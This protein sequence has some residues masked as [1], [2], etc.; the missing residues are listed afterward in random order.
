[1]ED[2][3]ASQDA[4]TLVPMSLSLVAK[5]EK[6]LQMEATK[7]EK[8]LA[9]RNEM[10]GGLRE[11]HEYLLT[12][13]GQLQER[14]HLRRVKLASL[15]SLL[16]ADQEHD[17]ADK[18]GLG[19]AIGVNELEATAEKCRVLKDILLGLV[20]KRAGLEQHCMGL[21]E[22]TARET[23]AL[24][25]KE[26]RLDEARNSYLLMH[27]D[28]RSTQ[29]NLEIDH[30]DLTE[31]DKH[32]NAV[33]QN[34]QRHAATVE[35]ADAALRAEKAAVEDLQTTW[36][37]YESMAHEEHRQLAI[38]NEDARSEQRELQ[39]L[40]E[41]NGAT[42][43]ADEKV[44][45]AAKDLQLRLQHLHEEVTSTTFFK[46]EIALRIK[47]EKDMLAITQSS[48]KAK[49]E[50]LTWL[51][52]Q[53]VHVENEQKEAAKAHAAD[54]AAYQ[55][56][57]EEHNT[58][59]AT[60]ETQIK[61]AGK[62]VKTTER[63][64]TA[65]NKK[66]AAVNKKVAHK[67][68]VL[69]EWKA[70]T[71]A[72]QDQVSKSAATQE[73]VDAEVLGMQE[74]LEQQL[75]H[76]KHTEQLRTTQEME[77]EELRSSCAVLE[78]EIQHTRKTLATMKNSIAATQT[79]VKNR[80][81]EVRDKFLSTFVV[82]DAE[83]LIKLL[84]K[85][86]S[87]SKIRSWTL[88]DTDEVDEAISSETAK[89]K[90]RYDTLAA[91]TRK[92]YA[93][94]LRQKEKQYLT[95][96][97]KLRKR[98]AEKNV[99]PTNISV[100]NP[101]TSKEVELEKPAHQDHV[102]ATGEEEEPAGEKKD[103]EAESKKLGLSWMERPRD[104]VVPSKVPVA[105]KRSSKLKPTQRKAKGLPKQA[106]KSA[107]RQLAPG[108]NLVDESPQTDKELTDPFKV[109]VK[110]ATTAITAKTARPSVSQ[111][112]R[113]SG[114][115]GARQPRLKRRTPAQKAGKPVAPV[116][117]TAAA[118]I[119]PE[120]ALSVEI[121]G[122]THPNPA[123]DMSSQDSLDSPAGCIVASR[124]AQDSDSAS[125]AK[126]TSE[127]AVSALASQGTAKKPL[128]QKAGQRSKGAVKRR[129]SLKASHRS[130]HS[131]VS[132]ISLGRSQPGGRTVD[133]TAVDSFSFN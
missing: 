64:V 128:L 74:E 65:R 43:P 95:K 129:T 32:L 120:A 71:D 83:I 22:E 21:E 77:S 25:V 17:G 92:N 102:S 133:W 115:N 15:R 87:G 5:K 76:L 40:F 107:R 88:K 44:V 106:P 9:Q 24:R 3:P 123:A 80:I 58:A 122:S 28:I 38:A 51:E 132:R 37:N 114:T 101:Q 56:F 45:E 54:E 29:W 127:T 72:K 46:R 68:K 119:T 78:Y 57:I 49:N 19:D 113:L 10:L 14:N 108:L 35:K 126:K 81:D 111:Q 55:T 30:A 39:K 59:M 11:T 112:R 63:A 85:E 67:T 69:A 73:L 66:V 98:A 103:R 42:C 116:R 79:A 2:T 75:R 104:E 109:D 16:E 12:T 47:Q 53:R 34:A 121:E 33:S 50:Q 86:A 100:N 36:Q 97:E 7:L 70:K 13:N 60:L 125:L 99:K 82:D 91:G 4:K 26:E 131:N 1:M 48:I 8:L 93:K 6:I 61:D 27:E 23:V 18:S 62:Q 31:Q 84:N 90:E 96:L 41:R 105:K 89:L 94:T 117:G 124:P 118:S 20:D 110:A 130:R 52:R